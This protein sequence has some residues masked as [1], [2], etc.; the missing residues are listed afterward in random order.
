MKS[1]KILILVFAPIALVTSCVLLEPDFNTDVEDPKE[2]AKGN[3]IRTINNVYEHFCVKKQQ[4]VPVGYSDN[5]QRSLEPVYR[6]CKDPASKE[7]LQKIE[8]C[9]QELRKSEQ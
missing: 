7:K 9:I 1:L 2:T 5:L 4:K 3:C 8:L 6:S